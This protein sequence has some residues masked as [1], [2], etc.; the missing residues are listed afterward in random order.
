M[1]LPGGCSGGSYSRVDGKVEFYG[2]I[3]SLLTPDSVVLDFGAGRGRAVQEDPVNRRR[4]LATLKGK[5]KKVIGVDIDTA[6]LM[7]PGLD[8]THF[9]DMTAQLPLPDEFVD[10]VVSDAVFEHVDNSAHIA[11]ELSRVLKPDGWIC[12]I[13]LNRWG[14]IGVGINIIPNWL[15]TRMLRHLQPHRKEVDV[16]PTWYK[17]N[18]ARAFKKYFNPKEWNHCVYP[19]YAE[20][21]YFGYS[22]ALWSAVLFANRFTPPA[23]APT[24]LIFLQKRSTGRDKK[25]Y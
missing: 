6:V 1:L 7:N 15:H 18:S 21:A 11:D 20:P 9:M 23:I 2:R 4:E 5:C 14:Y 19:C 22:R 17:L 10:I 3:Q 8:E 25:V 24:L 16:F 13:T 12:A